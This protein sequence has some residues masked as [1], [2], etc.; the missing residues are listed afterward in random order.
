MR[1]SRTLARRPHATTIH[2]HATS[3]SMKMPMDAIASRVS[4]VKI[5]DNASKTYLTLGVG[6]HATTRDV[7]TNR[8]PSALMLISVGP[9]CGLAA[10]TVELLDQPLTTPLL[11]AAPPL[12]E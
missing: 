10:K 6:H 5:V 2:A 1:K 11:E 12:L 3:G 7:Q 4:S 8:A 9:A